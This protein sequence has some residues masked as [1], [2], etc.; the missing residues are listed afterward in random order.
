MTGRAGG[1]VIGAR[2][3]TRRGFPASLAAP[4]LVVDVLVQAVMQFLF[5][6]L[7]VAM[8]AGTGR[9]SAVGGTVAAVVTVAAPTLGRFHFVQRP[10]GLRLVK[11]VLSRV[12]V[13][14]VCL[15]FGAI[16][17]PYSRLRSTCANRSGLTAAFVIHSAI[18]L[19]GTLEVSLILI[20]MG[21]PAIYP[22]ALNIESLLRAIRGAAFA[23]PGALGA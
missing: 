23:I 14:R 17:A 2:A 1:E 8:L 22:E 10:A 16:E 9:S 11:A 21:F 7:G 3:L 13:K 5:A 19:F 6:A 12:A 18:W 4:S 15:S 20:A